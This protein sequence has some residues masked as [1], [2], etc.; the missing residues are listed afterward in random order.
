MPDRPQFTPFDM[1]R[2]S[3]STRRQVYDRVA[4]LVWTPHPRD[5]HRRS[6]SPDEAGLFVFFVFGRWFAVWRNRDEPHLPEHQRTEVV[7]V[8]AD[9]DSPFEIVLAEV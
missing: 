1:S 8:Q 2:V 7:R 3:E 4:D 9:P 6:D 5:E